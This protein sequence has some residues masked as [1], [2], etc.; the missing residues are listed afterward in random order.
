MRNLARRPTKKMDEEKMLERLRG[1]EPPQVKALLERRVAKVAISMD[2][3]VRLC[4]VE[5][6]EAG[7]QEG[8]EN[9]CSCGKVFKEISSLQTHGQWCIVAGGNRQAKS[10]KLEEIKLNMSKKCYNEK[11]DK[12]RKLKKL[13]NNVKAH[14]NL[15]T[16]SQQNREFGFGVKCLASDQGGQITT[17]LPSLPPS[18][19]LPASLPSLSPATPS[20]WQSLSLLTPRLLQG[21]MSLQG[22]GKETGLQEEV[23]RAWRDSIRRCLPAPGQ[24]L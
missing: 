10:D 9:C 1:F 12:I 5:R 8:R 21:T 11:N 23:V 22:V 17:L 3:V 18:L 20:P 15:K 7:L 4:L 2:W 6:G 16:N 24:K 13:N 19:P 14:A